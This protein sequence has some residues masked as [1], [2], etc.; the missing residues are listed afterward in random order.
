MIN[1]E[2]SNYMEYKVN[3]DTTSIPQNTNATQTRSILSNCFDGTIS[4]YKRDSDLQKEAKYESGW[5][6]YKWEDLIFCER[7]YIDRNHT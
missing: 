7:R 2:E 3:K 4:T 6:K 1:D 5:S